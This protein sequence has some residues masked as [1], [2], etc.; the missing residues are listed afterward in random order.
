MP[1]VLSIQVRTWMDPPGSQFPLPSV[2]ITLQ[3][4]PRH[5]PEV[6][7][8]RQ[9]P[10]WAPVAQVQ[11]AWWGTHLS[12]VFLSRAHSPLPSQIPSDLLLFS[13]SVM[14]DSFAT[15][16]ILACQ[17]PLSMGFPRKEY[18]SG[19]LFPSPGDLPDPGTEP[20]SPTWQ[21]DFFTTE[22]LGK[23]QTLRSPINKLPTVKA[24]SRV[25]SPGKCKFPQSFLLKDIETSFFLLQHGKGPWVF[26]F[27]TS[28]VSS[29]KW[30]NGQIYS[31]CDDSELK[32]PYQPSWGPL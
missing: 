13:R 11:F 12:A 29:Y 27:K 10:D 2:G 19:L 5:L 24:Q 3:Q 16:W 26:F 31:W 8:S 9:W 22:S 14:S 23:P 32:F 28:S 15:Q 25:L 6:P 30:T 4:A 17:A 20:A 18:R 7:S 1:A 21:I